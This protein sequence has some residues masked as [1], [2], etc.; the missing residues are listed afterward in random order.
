MSEKA[1]HRRGER[2]VAIV[3]CIIDI[4]I[5]VNKSTRNEKVAT[6]PISDVIDNCTTFTSSDN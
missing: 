4:Q 3:V 2:S 5:I 1:S 6:W